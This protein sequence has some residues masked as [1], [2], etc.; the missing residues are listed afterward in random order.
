M[1]VSDAQE[2]WA[3][4]SFFNS[5][6]LHA[7]PLKF[8]VLLQSASFLLQIP[9]TALMTFTV[10]NKFVPSNIILNVSII[11]FDSGETDFFF[12]QLIN[13]DIY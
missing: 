13:Y 10:I 3:T 12:N 9:S 1:I 4:S 8:G 7:D 6:S 2:G 5:E 11:Y